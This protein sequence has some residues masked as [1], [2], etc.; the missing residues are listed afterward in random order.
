[1]LKL[2][3]LINEFVNLILYIM[4]IYKIDTRSKIT[5]CEIIYNRHSVSVLCWHQTYCFYQFFISFLCWLIYNILE[6][7]YF[8]V[9]ENISQI[10]H[11]QFHKFRINQFFLLSTLLMCMCDHKESCLGHCIWR[12]CLKACSQWNP[13]AA[14][15]PHV[16]SKHSNPLRHI[17]FFLN[18][19]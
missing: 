2:C 19:F 15:Q 16:K 3:Y 12:G 11:I 13:T 8:S 18:A 4:L 5:F 6:S 14:M 1:M 17:C 7:V 10:T 9:P